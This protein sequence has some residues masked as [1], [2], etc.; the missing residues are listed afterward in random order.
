MVR[1]DEYAT[2]RE[3]IEAY[4]LSDLTFGPLGMSMI[5]Q[6]RVGEGG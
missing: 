4:T 5:F 3:R 6:R 2:K 1:N